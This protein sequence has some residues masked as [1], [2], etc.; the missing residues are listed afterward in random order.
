M[1]IPKGK[2]IKAAAQAF[3]YSLKVLPY[4]VAGW[5]VV[6]FL[7][8]Y[9]NSDLAFMQKFD[10]AFGFWRYHALRNG[11]KGL[12]LR[13]EFVLKLDAAKIGFVTNEIVPHYQDWW[14]WKNRFPNYGGKWWHVT[15]QDNCYGFRY[16]KYFRFRGKL[17]YVESKLGWRIGPYDKHGPIENS[18]RWAHGATPTLQIIKFGTAGSDYK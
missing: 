8:K 15:W 3:M 4:K 10:G 5:F 11:A 9:R 18:G 14:L 13:P 2:V 1:K 6:P 17:R 12:R 7:W 16:I